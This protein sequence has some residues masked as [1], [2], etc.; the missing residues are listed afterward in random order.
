MAIGYACINVGINTIDSYKSITVKNFNQEKMFEV[1][2]HNLKV[3]KD[4]LEYNNKNNIKL[5]RIS[6]NIIPLATHE[7]NTFNWQD[8][9]KSELETIGK[10]IKENNIRVSMHPGQYTVLN[11]ISEQVVL[12]AVE[13]LEYHCSF[14][15]CLGVDKTNKIVLHIG[16]VY[17]NKSKS[18]ERFISNYK[19][20]SEAVKDRLV[21]ENDE[22]SYNIK[23]VYE[24]GEKTDIPV[25][26]DNLHHEINTD[27]TY[28]E[29]EWIKKCITTWR[30]EDG[31]AKIHYSN[32]D[33]EKKRGSHSK[34]IYIKE[35]MQFYNKLESLELDIMLEVKDKNLSA[36]KCIHC[37]THANVKTLENVWAKYKYIILERNHN[38]YL[39]I[40][41]YLK[42]REEANA[43]ELYTLIEKS[44]STANSDGGY[45]NGFDHVWGYFKKVCTVNEKE[46]YKKKL[47][48]FNEGKIKASNMKKFLYKMTIKYNSKYLIESYYFYDII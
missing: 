25:I 44:L 17:D 21:I 8:E 1:I 35:F 48:D 45:R 42:N 36:L 39:E 16:G 38:V 20:L 43:F 37:T 32:Q 19:K 12:K 40:R 26:F 6:S 27:S 28:T 22:K 23:D 30:K 11:S 14:L 10:Y 29:L 18:I 46:L 4:T 5:F 47:S 2:K 9:F 33:Y 31:K 7:I 3:L 13:D 41:K 15:D 24:I 34:Y